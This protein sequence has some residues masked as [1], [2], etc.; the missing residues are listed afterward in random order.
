M[1]KAAE[2]VA[3][4]RVAVMGY[5]W[6]GWTA[7]DVT[8]DAEGE[9]L[10]NDAAS[11]VVEMFIACARWCVCVF[12]L[13]VCVCVCVFVCV[14]VCVCVFVCVCLFVCVCVFVCVC[15]CVCVCLF[16]RLL[17][18]GFEKDL[19]SIIELLNDKSTVSPFSLKA[20]QNVRSLLCV[21]PTHAVCLF[22]A[23]P[24]RMLSVCL[25]Q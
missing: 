15:L 22:V 2:G 25:L 16:R 1:K 7:D 3:V 19:N 23:V 21:A 14:C 11:L 6:S 8:G 9:L 18:L 10:L 24:P 4:A 17:D 12:V 13:F 5:D 20:R